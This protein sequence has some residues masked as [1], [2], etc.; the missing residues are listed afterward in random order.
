LDAVYTGIAIIMRSKISM[1]L[2]YSTNGNAFIAEPVASEVAIQVPIT[3][4]ILR[5]KTF[6]CR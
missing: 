4:V 2:R 3:F 6:T 5:K 1:L